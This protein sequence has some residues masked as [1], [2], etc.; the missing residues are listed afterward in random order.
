ME[1]PVV[2]IVSD[3]TVTRQTQE[4]ATTNMIL[5]SNLEEPHSKRY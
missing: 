3:F 1:F 4:P 2:Q 5:V